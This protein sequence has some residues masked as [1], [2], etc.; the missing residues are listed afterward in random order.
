MVDLKHRRL[1]MTEAVQLLLKPEDI[2]DDI[3]YRSRA[4]SE[5]ADIQVQLGADNTERFEV[6][7]NGWRFNFIPDQIT[8][9][10]IIEV[11]VRRRYTKGR[12]QRLWAFTQ[13]LLQADLL[14][15]PRFTIVIYSYDDQKIEHEQSFTFE[16]QVIRDLADALWHRLFVKLEKLRS[17]LLERE[18]KLILEAVEL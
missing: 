12:D 18:D 4:L 10:G 11:K 14:N 1:S 7:K 5:N 15:K 3:Y 2:V 6:E 9:D 17:T 8:D 13:A 16:D